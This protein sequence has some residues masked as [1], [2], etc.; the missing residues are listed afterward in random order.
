MRQIK[1]V[2][3]KTCNNCGSSNYH[4]VTESWDFEFETC[5]NI[6][7]FVECNNCKQ[8]RILNRPKI[9]E[10]STIYSGYSTYEYDEY[11]GSSISLLRNIVQ[12]LKI[13][14][15]S[16]NAKNSLMIVDVGCGTCQLLREIQKHGHKNWQLVGIDISDAS[17]KTLKRHNMRG[18]QGRFEDLIWEG[19]R[20]DII[21]MNQLIEHLEDPRRCVEKAFEILAPGGRLIIETPCIEGWD[22]KIFRERYWGGWHVP[23]HWH[24]FSTKTLHNT[25]KTSG[26]EIQETTYLLNP[27]AWLQSLRFRMRDKGYTKI[28]EFFQCNNFIAL[29][30]A[31]SIDVVQKLVRRK[32]SNMR[33]VGIKPIVDA[34]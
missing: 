11:L 33:V 1:T 18:V 17:M 7:E 10:I 8:I 28:G 29:C 22:A 30:L 25:L 23:R 16:R 13:K 26:F 21:I 2:K 12:R 20:P 27:Y 6:F 14:S 15:F 34:P 5:S 4:K 19:K 9:L 3:A 31:S 24:L 32:T